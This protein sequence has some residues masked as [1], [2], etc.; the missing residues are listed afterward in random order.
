MRHVLFPLFLLPC[1]GAPVLADTCED[2]IRALYSAP[3]GLFDPANLVPQEHAVTWVYPDGTTAPYNT[4]RWE[5]P[6]RVLNESNN[7]YYLLYDGAYYQ[8]PGWEGP[9]TSMGQGS[10]DDPIA[11]ARGMNDS[12]L[13]SLEDMRCD[14]EVD[15]EGRKVL[16]YAYHARTEPPEVGSWWEANYVLY[17]DAET[18]QRVRIEEHALSESWAPVAKEE[19]RVTRV[20]LLPGYTIP[21]PPKAP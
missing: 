11:F 18:G 7:G 10:D 5:S 17:V 9:W 19:V 20:T 16:R 4:A 21:N 3:D 14:G 13:A 6:A 15:L 8:G 12:V 1:L 2:E